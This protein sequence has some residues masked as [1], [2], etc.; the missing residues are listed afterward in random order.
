MS[1]YRVLNES[2][3]GSIL[4]G[5]P[6]QISKDV[7]Y[8]LFQKCMHLQWAPNLSSLK[9]S[10][11]VKNTA[12]IFALGATLKTF[13]HM[14]NRKDQ[15]ASVSVEIPNYCKRVGYYYLSLGI[16]YLSV[17][18]LGLTNLLT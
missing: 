6:V 8:F 2:V 17:L 5:K 4:F 1:N 9:A 15:F 13:F 14:N 7:L 10:G 11:Q 16:V 18:T 12:D 3:D